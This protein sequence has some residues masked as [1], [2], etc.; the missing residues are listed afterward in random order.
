MEHSAQTHLQRRAFFRFGSAAAAGGGLLALNTV[1]AA[2]ADATTPASLSIPSW[3]TT[4]RSYNEALDAY[5]LRPN[6]LSRWR[7]ARTRA[8]AG[9]GTGHITTFL[10]SITATQGVP[11]V[12]EPK[13]ANAWYGRLNRMLEA[14]YGRAGSGIVVPWDRWYDKPA[15]D[16]RLTMTGTVTKHTFGPHQLGCIRWLN[17]GGGNFVEF[18]DTC[19]EFVLYMVNGGSRPRVQVDGGPVKF[20]AGNPNTDVAQTDYDPE[21]G[22]QKTATG[23]TG[24]IVT[25][26][27]A[28]PFAPH[29]IRIYAP[30]N[31]TSYAYLIGIEGRTGAAGIRV[32]NLARSGLKMAEFIRDD[33]AA[34]LSGLPTSLDMP[35]A[36]LAIMLLGMNDYQAHRDIPTFKANVT[37]VVQRQKSSEAFRANGDVLLVTCPQPN[38]SYP[39][40]ADGVLTPP[41]AEYY[42]ALYEVADE[43]DIPLLDLANRW[44]DFATS[45]ALGYFADPLHPNNLGSE[46]IATAI[47]NVLMAV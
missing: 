27:P 16:A 5:N 41:L 10:D 9:L 31:N 37:T 7:A 46:E 2:P 12:S 15:E 11:G 18:T 39:I 33:S 47:H 45:N 20:I 24:Q 23:S 40:P 1:N 19:T 8:A 17:G 28:G 34:Y 26:V 44:K 3:G 35:K 30:T 13:Y 14:S 21:P 4:T 6:N 29:T 43:Q 38:Y 36:D 32:S 22:Y 42:T 25:R